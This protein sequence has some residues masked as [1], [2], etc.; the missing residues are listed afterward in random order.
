MTV[1]AGLPAGAQQALLIAANQAF[2]TSLHVVA[3]TTGVVL[4]GVALLAL[5]MLRHVPRIGSAPVETDPTSPTRST[6]VA[7]LALA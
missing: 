3:G 6:E 1:A 4:V 2:N 7:D 5:T